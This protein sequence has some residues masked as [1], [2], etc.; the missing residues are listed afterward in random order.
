MTFRPTAELAALT[1]QHEADH[2]DT[3]Q[4]PR[5]SCGTWACPM[6][7]ALTTPPTLPSPT[8]TTP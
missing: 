8:T 2:Q 3:G 5:C 1:A 6:L 4:T 7:A